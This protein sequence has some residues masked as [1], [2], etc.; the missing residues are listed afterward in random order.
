[1]QQLWAKRI[2]DAV[3]TGHVDGSFIDGN[4]GGWGFGN[5]AAC[6]GDKECESGL[7]AG[8]E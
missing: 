4:R 1:M 7:K 2:T 8:L 5:C 3:A 6:Q